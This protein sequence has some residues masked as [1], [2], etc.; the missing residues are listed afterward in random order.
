MAKA[1]NADN[2]NTVASLEAL[3]NKW[4]PIT[5]VI[6][7]YNG[8]CRDKSY[9]TVAPPHISGPACSEEISSGILVSE[10]TSLATAVPKPPSSWLAL[11][12]ASW[13]RQY[14]SW[15]VELL[16]EHCHMGVMAA[17]VKHGLQ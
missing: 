16:V 7:S 14:M 8:K 10:V 12:N 4:T 3:M 5:Q 6:R 13:F 11:P 9:Q 2:S 15:P 1:S 17:P